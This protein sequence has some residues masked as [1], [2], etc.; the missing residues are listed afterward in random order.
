MYLLITAFL[1]LLGICI[2]IKTIVYGIYEIRNC[3]NI[4]G[5]W[6]V[7]IFSIV[8]FALFSISLVIEK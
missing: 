2:T 4:F 6:F 3:K 5:G 1:F 7:I 8:T